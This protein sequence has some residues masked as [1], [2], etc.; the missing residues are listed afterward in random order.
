MSKHHIRQNP[1]LGFLGTDTA[2]VC[3]GFRTKAWYPSSPLNFQP[4]DNNIDTDVAV[5]PSA[6]AVSRLLH[7]ARL[8]ALRYDVDDVAHL[9]HEKVG[10]GIL[11]LEVVAAA[12]YGMSD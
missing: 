11:V 3:L 7:V 6:T 1:T 5:L 12:H 10:H 2:R 8:E 9:V 4:R